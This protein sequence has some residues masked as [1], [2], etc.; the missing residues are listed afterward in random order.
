M[1]PSHLGS[2]LQLLL[3]DTKLGLEV[4]SKVSPDPLL[5]LSSA[6]LY[7]LTAMTHKYC[8]REKKNDQFNSTLYT[9]YLII[10]TQFDDELP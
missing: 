8:L 2:P 1:L 5:Y 3:L 7:Y 10:T 9:G 4:Q 6:V